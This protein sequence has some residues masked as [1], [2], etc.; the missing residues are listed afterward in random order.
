[1]PDYSPHIMKDWEWSKE[2]LQSPG[3]EKYGRLFNT[4]YSFLLSIPEGKFFDIQKVQESN[5]DFFIK[6]C[7][8]FVLEQRRYI[9]DF[10]TL[11]DDY[12]K[13]IHKKHV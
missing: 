3:A 6:I 12:T 9:G 5:R 7:C 8:L 10:W 4:I 11:S 2:Y 1:M 13:F